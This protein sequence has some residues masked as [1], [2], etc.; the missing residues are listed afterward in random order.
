M[1]KCLMLAAMLLVAACAA[2]QTRSPEITSAAEQA[3]AAKQRELVVK[4]FVESAKHLYRVGYPLLAHGAPLCGKKVFPSVGAVFWSKQS[5]QKREMQEAVESQYGITDLIQAA[6]VA[7]GAPGDKAGLKEGD[8]L[9]LLDGW[10][11]PVSKDAGEQFSKRFLD[12]RKE[13]R[14]FE[15]MVRRKGL[16]YRLTVE[17]EPVCD[18]E[19]VMEPQDAKIAY[20]LGRRI[21]VSRGMMDF[22]RTDEE[23]AMVIAH[24][25]AHFAMGHNDAKK[26]N[27]L[28]GSLF[29][30][31]MDVAAAASGLN[32]GGSFT[33]MGMNAGTGT[34][35]VDFEREADYVGLY[36]MAIAG[37]EV[38]GVSDF[39]RRMAIQDP[40]AIHRRS[41]HPTTPERY[42][43]ME[44]TVAK[45]KDK[46][47]KGLPLEPE[48]KKRG[49]KHASWSNPQD[50]GW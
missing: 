3:E 42:V 20:L 44:K 25:L 32:T 43:E 29:G 14:A 39:W 1:R 34:D 11:I 45:I 46:I 18:V 16:D 21:V 49:T 30:I 19:L 15:L 2:P 27:A 8:V 4:E 36:L 13:N 47:N 35:S 41:A 33:Q 12:V 38:D 37:Y 10:P 22:F 40:R 28:L 9:L 50:Q 7:P 24:E 48:T 6:I 31:V 23:A 5:F 17:P 26:T